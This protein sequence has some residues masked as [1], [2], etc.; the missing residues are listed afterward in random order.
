[1]THPDLTALAAELRRLEAAATPPPWNDVSSEGG[2]LI[3]SNAYDD[4]TPG[5][6]GDHSK[7]W[8]LDMTD[9]ALICLLR[10][11]AATLAEAM[12]VVASGGRDHPC[13]CEDCR[14]DGNCS[15]YVANDATISRLTRELESALERVAALEKEVE[16]LDKLQAHNF[17][18][19]AM[20]CNQ[21][22]ELQEKLS[23]AS[24]ALAKQREMPEALPLVVDAAKDAAEG[25]RNE[26]ELTRAANIDDAVAAVESFYAPASAGQGEPQRDCCH[27]ARV[28]FGQHDADCP[29][30]Q[31]DK[32][33]GK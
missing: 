3:V 21:V 2:G 27:D 24:S 7:E 17:N 26:G 14:A 9:A 19:G 15:E 6:C 13:H 12:E 16:E 33:K 31:G 1:M 30:G 29:N 10:N 4:E 18:E 8:P 11:N 5:V 22:V 23:A 25:W 28:H 20:A 32:E